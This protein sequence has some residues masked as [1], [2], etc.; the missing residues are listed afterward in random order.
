M[1][2]YIVFIS[3]KLYIF[4]QFSFCSRRKAA[5]VIYFPASV[6]AL[7]FDKREGRQTVH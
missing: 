3:I 1:M 6:T 7:M 4:R 2:S 5:K